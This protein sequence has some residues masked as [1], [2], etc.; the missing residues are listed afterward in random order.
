MKKCIYQALPISAFCLAV[1]Q[2]AMAQAA[3]TPPP[4]PKAPVT[5]TETKTEAVIKSDQQAEAVIKSD[6]QE[7]IIR[8]KGDKDTKITLEIKNGDYFINGK[9]LEKFDDNNIIIEKREADDEDAMVMAY[10]PSPFRVNPWNEDRIERQEQERAVQDMKRNIQK[11]IKIKMNT[12]FLG[13][14]S[15]ASDKG[16]ATVLEVT[17]GS[18]AEKAGIKKGDIIK[19]INDTKVDNPD[20]LFEAVHDYKPGDKV[21]ILF[22]RDGK[23]Q[24]VVATLDKNDFSPKTY[25]FDYKYKSPEMDMLPRLGEMGN[26]DFNWNFG[27][28]KMGIKA[29][30]AEDGKGVTVLEV[31]DSS[32]AWK[33]G[34]KKGDIIL[35]VDGNDVNNVNQLLEQT[36]SVADKQKYTYK[37]KI[38]RNGAT[39]EVEVKIPRKL[40]TAEL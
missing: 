21:K 39:Q 37:L 36:M 15:R 40:K 13:I 14:S 24:T 30:D 4:P 10:S 34:L 38:Q 1:G 9:P 7:I 25:S 6:Q 31:T 12:A 8:Q 16:G 11:S 32:A 23:D 17:K 2:L 18:P 35:Q 27:R 26:M 29:Q 33:A 19:K 3:V 5:K 22:T 28:P 20:M